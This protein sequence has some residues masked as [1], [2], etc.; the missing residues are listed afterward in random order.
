MGEAT[1]RAAQHRLLLHV[2]GHPR[3]LPSS[4]AFGF[5]L[6]KVS[7]ALLSAVQRRLHHHD[8]GH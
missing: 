7:E 5:M 3:A 1:L 2:R 4:G 6:W 8:R